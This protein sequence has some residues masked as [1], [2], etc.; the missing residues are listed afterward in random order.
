[1]TRRNAAAKSCTALLVFVAACTQSEI[2]QSSESGAGRIAFLG[3]EGCANTPKLLA[4]L[5]SALKVAGSSMA[6]TEVDQLKLPAT[7]P[8]RGYPTPT[9]LLDGKDI[10][11]MPEPEPP[12]TNTSCRFYKEGLPTSEMIAERLIERLE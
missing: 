10:F 4:N 6:Y 2:P 8:R 11:G 3:R 12:F 7:D 1:M 9:I 5:E